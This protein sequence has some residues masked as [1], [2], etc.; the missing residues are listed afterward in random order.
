MHFSGVIRTF[1]TNFA[2]VAWTC[3]QDCFVVLNL[4]SVLQYLGFKQQIYVDFGFFCVG[5]QSDF[6]KYPLKP[7]IFRI[8]N[9]QAE[10]G[11]LFSMWSLGRDLWMKKEMST[12][13]TSASRN[14][15]SLN[16]LYCF[17][18]TATRIFLFL[19]GCAWAQ[20]LHLKDI[21]ISS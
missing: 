2:F 7:F 4:F 5:G 14:V 20:L 21:V 13:L 9:H 16:K 12:V 15:S 8:L 11:Y 10:A 19:W 18:L 6:L 3:K 1:A 17:K